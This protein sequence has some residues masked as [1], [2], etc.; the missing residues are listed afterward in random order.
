MREEHGESE[1]HGAWFRCRGVEFVQQYECHDTLFPTS[2][3]S[4]ANVVS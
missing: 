1:C 4:R 3:H 2:W